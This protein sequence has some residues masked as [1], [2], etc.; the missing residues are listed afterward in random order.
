MKTISEICQLPL[1]KVQSEVLHKLNPNKI[2]IIQAPT[3]VGKSFI[4]AHIA[5]KH[6][7]AMI[8]TPTRALQKQYIQEMQIE[9]LWGKAHYDCHKY[10]VSCD[11]C[12]EHFSSETDHLNDEGK[13]KI[14]QEH[15]RQCEYKQEKAAFSNDRYGVTGVEICYFGIRNQSKCLIIDEAHNLI[16]KFSNLSGCKIS[17]KSTLF[18]DA[19]K[20]L[21]SRFSNNKIGFEAYLNGC[22]REAK[23][24]SADKNSARKERKTKFIEKLQVICGKQS[25]FS[26]EVVYD[27]NS[28]PSVELK[29]LNF[30]FEFAKLTENFD[31]VYLMSAT[32]PDVP[33][34]C[35]LLGIAKSDM[36]FINVE[37]PFDP[38]KV[39]INCYTSLLQNK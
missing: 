11:Q 9:N 34:F 20:S 1:R 13:A 10:E 36:N 15:E 32:L 18:G 31:H 2:N 30:R 8:I 12:D 33:L 25:Y 35:A 21:N 6:K 28:V 17:S 14:S 29:K 7:G 16:D 19:F 5:Q 24:N 27:N 3:G 22:L 39:K 26:Y 38:S 23:R 4:A 37:S